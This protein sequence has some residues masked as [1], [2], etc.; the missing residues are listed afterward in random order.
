MSN[1][2]VIADQRAGTLNPQSLEVVVA[3][4]KLAAALG[5][6]LDIALIG[7]EIDSA[8]E[9][10][11][12]VKA[13][14]LFMVSD[15]VLEPYRAEA[16]DVA[17]K[18]LVTE[19]QPQYVLLPHT[20]LVRDFAPRL[21]AAFKRVLISDCVAFSHDGGQTVFTRQL[22]QGKINADVLA[23][24]D[25]PHFVSFQ[26]G[27]FRADQLQT[28]GEPEK[29]AMNAPFEAATLT[30]TSEAPVHE[31]ADGVDLSNVDII[32]S[33]GRGIQSEENIE[34]ARELAKALG[35]EVGASR[36]V[37]DAGWLSSDHQ[38]GSSG[39]SVTPK[40]YLALG[41]S[42]SIQHM[43]GAKGAKTIAAINTDPKAP[44]FA[45]ADYGVVGDVLEVVPALIEELQ[46]GG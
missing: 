12:N 1:V 29:K 28:D 45:A 9:S 38:I 46:S 39:Q 10:F 41:I 13:S 43:V 8:A 42:G 6:D 35:G 32:V 33:V 34:I 5:V 37:C 19:L 20:Y 11:A 40:L 17:G 18:T 25:A 30:T 4:Q 36:P 14:R 3:G 21:A 26:A 22:F 16:Y 27:A 15:G 44:I 7:G 23:K 24:G 2:L 31:M